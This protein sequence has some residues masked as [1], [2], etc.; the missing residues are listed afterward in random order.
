MSFAFIPA[1]PPHPGQWLIRLRQNQGGRC[2]D[3]GLKE[4]HGG[5]WAFSRARGPLLPANRA[6]AGAV[7]RAGL[8]GNFEALLLG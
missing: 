8:R 4:A 1:L 2:L 5:K 6:E 7:P 3:N